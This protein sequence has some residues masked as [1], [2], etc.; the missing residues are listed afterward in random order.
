M[1]AY[2]LESIKAV[3]WGITR[4]DDALRKYEKDFDAAVE[5]SDLKQDTLCLKTSHPYYHQIQGQLHICNKTCCD[6][7]VW[8]RVDCIVIRIVKDMEWTANVSKLID[9]YFNIFIPALMEN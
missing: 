9:F 4:E 7:I 6:L 2:N 8:T 5:Q 1:S 3:A